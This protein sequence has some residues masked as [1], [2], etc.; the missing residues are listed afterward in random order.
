[1]KYG[2]KI[3]KLSEVNIKL[4]GKLP[5]TNKIIKFKIDSTCLH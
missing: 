1:M 4:K 2:A 3:R 5:E